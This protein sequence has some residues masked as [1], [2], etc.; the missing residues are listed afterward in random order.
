M[1]RADDSTEGSGRIGQPIVAR[2]VAWDTV[3]ARDAAVVLDSVLSGDRDTVVGAF[4]TA[5]ERRGMRGVYDVAWCLA[6]ALVG[7]EP[8]ASLVGLDFPEIDRAPYDTRWVARFA[9]AYANGDPP[10]GEA[11]F[12]A[13][14]A[15]GRLTQCLVALASSTVATLRHRGDRT[16]PEGLTAPQT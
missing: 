5:V 9:S 16:Y 8:A 4:D 1:G 12:S 13:A 3:I 15:D 11:L 6:A 10:S 2:G 14:M 7:T